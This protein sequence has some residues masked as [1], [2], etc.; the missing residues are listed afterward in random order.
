MEEEGEMRKES[1]LPT[2]LKWGR[3]STAGLVSILGL[4]CVMKEFL[5]FTASP[6]TKNIFMCKPLEA[7]ALK[8][9]FLPIS[10]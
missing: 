4:I 10:H 7:G 9:L 3:D 8:E 5:T 6:R 1:N 2:S